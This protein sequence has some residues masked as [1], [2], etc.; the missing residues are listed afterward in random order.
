MIR[1]VVVAGKRGYQRTTRWTEGNFTFNRIL[2]RDPL[3]PGRRFDIARFDVN[4][5]SPPFD[6][7]N[8]RGTV[9]WR[10]DSL[11]LD[12]N[13]LDGS[14]A[15]ATL[16]LEWAN[17]RLVHYNLLILSDSSRSTSRITPSIPAL[18]H[19]RAAHQDRPRRPA[20]P[21][22]LTKMDLRTRAS[23]PARRDD[24]RDRRP[25]ADRGRDVSVD[26]TPPAFI[27]TMNGGPFP[28]PWH[29]AFTGSAPAVAW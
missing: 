6:V 19:R 17:N 24:I 22:L 10:G 27:E 26:A 5:Q 15:R 11:T 18:V 8:M 28:Q 13:H 29:G 12:I 16:T 20:S 23:H 7:R 4:E 3:R 25:S 14:V 9:L 21:R 1:P 2:L